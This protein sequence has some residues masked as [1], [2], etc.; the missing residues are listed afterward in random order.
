MCPNITVKHEDVAGTLVIVTPQTKLQLYQKMKA[1]NYQVSQQDTKK[2]CGCAC[3][4][5]RVQTRGFG[6]ACGRV[7]AAER[8]RCACGR[9]YGRTW[10][11]QGLRSIVRSPESRALLGT[12]RYTLQL[13][14]LECVPLHRHATYYCRH[15]TSSAVTTAHFVSNIKNT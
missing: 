12:E 9:G 4:R 2:R 6:F 5:G 11:T 3:V 15:A 10:H 14:A 1:C 7:R 13:V 8:C